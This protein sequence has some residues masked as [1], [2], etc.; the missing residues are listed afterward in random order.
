MNAQ[1]LSKTDMWGTPS[2]ILDMVREVIG[3]I[4]LDPASCPE[5]NKNVQARR[6][7]TEN[8]DGLKDGFWCLYPCKIF[9]NP[10]SGKI[11]RVSKVK[12]FW[13][14][15]IDH[16]SEGLVKEA[17]FMG[18]SLE[19]LAILQDCTMHPFDFSVCIPRHRI[20]FVNL[21]DPS[22]LDC[23]THGNFI[24]HICDGSYANLSRFRKVFSKIGVVR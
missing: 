4:D 12:L 6:F 13:Q 14:K 1:H 3:P 21:S 8:E 17:I 11:N 22:H 16:Y 5:A 2:Y 20:K 19:Q 24:C 10:P 9:L 18:F 15:L 23:P 7:L